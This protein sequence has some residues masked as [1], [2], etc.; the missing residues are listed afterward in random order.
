MFETSDEL[1][2]LHNVE[3]WQQPQVDHICDLGIFTHLARNQKPS[4]VTEAAWKTVQDGVF[5][6]IP[7]VR[8][9]GWKG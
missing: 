2:R 1:D 4:G 3:T 5:G 7:S 6:K 9:E 8:L